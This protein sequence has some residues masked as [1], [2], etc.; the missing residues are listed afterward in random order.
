M[1]ICIRYSNVEFPK[2]V[3]AEVA[4]RVEKIEKLLKR[5]APD[6]VQLH[7][8]FEKHLHKAEFTCS[9]DLS[10]PTGTLCASAP[11]PNPRVSA[12][13]AFAELEAQIKKHQA[14]LRGDYE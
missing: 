13:N 12:R 2:V 3:E 7:G 8:S 10:L 5:Y 4:H 9:I 14:L 6:L 1:K 11:G